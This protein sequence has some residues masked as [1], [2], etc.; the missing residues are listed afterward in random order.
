MGIE[1]IQFL[2][3]ETEASETLYSAVADSETIDPASPPG[4]TNPGPS[5]EH[6]STT[7]TRAGRQTRPTW[8]VRDHVPE[9]EGVA[10]DSEALPP[11]REES[12]ELSCNRRLT[13]LV[14][15]RIRTAVNRFGLSRLY[16]RRPV[17]EPDSSIGLETVYTPTQSQRVPPPPKRAIHEI[18]APHPNFTTFLFNHQFWLAGHK[19][20]RDERAALRD[21]M[22]REDFKNEDMI[23]VN[24]D[25]LDKKLGSSTLEAPWVRES[26][27]WRRDSISIGIPPLKRPNQGERREAAADCQRVQRGEGLPA[28]SQRVGPT[29]GL[30]GVPL[31]VLDFWHKD[32]CAEIKHTFATDDAA[33]SFVFDPYLMYHARPGTNDIP[34]PVYSELF[35]AQAIVDEDIRIQH[36]PRQPGDDLPRA[37]AMMMYHSDVTHVTQFGDSKVWPGYLYFGNQTKYESSRP[38][39]HA[40]HHIA[41]FPS[42]SSHTM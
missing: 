39:C 28:E 37:M 11:P 2:R 3:R 31:T 40:A 38:S 9:G 5:L 22:V 7:M 29:P 15:E 18:I 34:E 8:K 30:E 36:L 35:N 10:F 12:M 26:D 21:V 17:Q 6:P 16:K 13:L 32:L 4:Y 27:G 1:N 33:R 42:V 41:F 24:F 25:Q 14:T 19:K 20:T 23:S